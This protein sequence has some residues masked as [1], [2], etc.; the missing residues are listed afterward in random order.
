MIDADQLGRRWCLHST[1]A[2][3]LRARPWDTRLNFS[4]WH[5]GALPYVNSSGCIQ[6][7][8]ASVTTMPTR[9]RSGPGAAHARQSQRF[10][11][12]ATPYLFAT[13][14][15][16]I[17]LAPLA[18]SMPQFDMLPALVLLTRELLSAGFTPRE[19][20]PQFV[21]NV[22]LAASTQHFG[23][24][25]QTIP[26]QSGNERGVAAVPDHHRHRCRPVRRGAAAFAKNR[27]PDEASPT[28]NRRCVTYRTDYV[29]Q[30]P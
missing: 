20:T 21:Q 2:D 23:S 15:M 6:Q 13:A 16:G 14:S 18:R 1:S 22:M 24:A 19:G 5:C 30:I 12:A 26:Y 29:S 28:R 11:L 4:Q 17:F 7:L 9:C 27:E 8:I 25:A 3:E 10:M